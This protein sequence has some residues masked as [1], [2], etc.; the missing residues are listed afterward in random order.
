MAHERNRSK[1]DA[2]RIGGVEM[3]AM[4]VLGAGA[5]GGLVLW[6]KWGFMVAFDAVITYCF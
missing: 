4:A 5:L 6:A 2:R 1:D 3:A